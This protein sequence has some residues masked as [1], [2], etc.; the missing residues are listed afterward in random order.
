MCSSLA[1]LDNTELSFR[2]HLGEGK[3][4]RSIK[5]ATGSATYR[6]AGFVPKLICGEVNIGR[7]AVTQMC[8]WVFR[9]KRCLLH[10]VVGCA[11]NS[12]SVAYCSSELCMVHTS[13]S[14]YGPL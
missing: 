7:V 2:N 9:C 6:A 8:L 11:S 14:T 4:K 5:T 13:N 1:F 3:N 10:Q 12:T